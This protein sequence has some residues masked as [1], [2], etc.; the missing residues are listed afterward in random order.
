MFP[1]SVVVSNSTAVTYNFN[2]SGDI[3]GTIGLTKTNT[4]TVII[5]NNNTYT[6]QTVFGG[7]TISVSSL[8]NG[9]LPGPIGAAS[10]NPTNLL[11]V[12]GPLAY[13]GSG[14]TD[15]GM[16]FTTNS[17]GTI[18]VANGAR[19]TLSGLIV[20]TNTTFTKTGPGTLVIVVVKCLSPATL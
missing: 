4:G 12:G 19:L 20:G 3:S 14:S 2:G 6:G 5:N 8:P 10:N 1:S 18:N 9:G 13:T 7:G 17:S 11:F 16:T 15:H